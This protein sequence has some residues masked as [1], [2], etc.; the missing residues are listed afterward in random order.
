MPSRLGVIAFLLVLGTSFLL[1]PDAE[2]Q[3]RYVPTSRG[4]L[5]ATEAIA[6][7]FPSWAVP[8]FV[9]IARCESGFDPEARS[10]GWD[11]IWGRYDYRGILQI[12]AG[13]H[14]VRA[15]RLFGPG[16]DLYDPWVNAHVAAEIFAEAGF[17]AW[18]WCRR[19]A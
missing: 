1:V 13:L 12:E 8:S 11:R 4:E 10:H 17:G 3:E 16:A 5:R 19:H 9:R 2:A 18:P 15:D 14:Q 7:A 6:E